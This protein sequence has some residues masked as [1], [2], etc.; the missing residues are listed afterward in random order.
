MWFAR[1]IASTRKTTTLSSTLAPNGGCTTIVLAQA[2]IDRKVRGH[3]WTVEIDPE[4]AAAARAN[5]EAAGVADRIPLI[6][7]DAK[8]SMAA[9]VKTLPPIRFAFLD[10]CQTRRQSHQP[11]VRL[12]VHARRGRL[13]EGA[14]SAMSVF[15]FRKRIPV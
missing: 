15:R 8:A 2:L 3:V 7:G 10:G 6:E 12:L 14:V 1:N 11:A 4:N 5:Y 9:L 13:A